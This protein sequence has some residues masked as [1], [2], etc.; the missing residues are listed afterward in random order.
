[1]K[2]RNPLKVWKSSITCTLV[3]E[4]DPTTFSTNLENL[5]Q[6]I[7][8]TTVICFAF[9]SERSRFPGEDHPTEILQPQNPEHPARAL[10]A[11]GRYRQLEN[12]EI[13]L[14]DVP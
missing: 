13:T 10:P 5:L 8:R 11:G 6:R 1:M 14:D 12:E 7:I 3:V 2:T 4:S 9:G